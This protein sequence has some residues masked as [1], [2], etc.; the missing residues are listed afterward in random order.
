[1][2]P[3]QQVRVLVLSRSL[4]IWGARL[5]DCLLADFPPFFSLDSFWRAL[6]SVDDRIHFAPNLSKWLLWEEPFFGFVSPSVHASGLDLESH[7]SQ[8]STYLS[9][10]LSVLP[11]ADPSDASKPARSITDHPFNAR[12]RFPYLLAETLKLKAG[13]RLRLHN[14]YRQEDWKTLRELA[15]REPESRMS[16]LRMAL[17]KL[18]KYHRQLWMSMYKVSLAPP[19]PLSFSPFYS[20]LPFGMLNRCSAS[21]ARLTAIRL[22]N[23]RTALRRSPRAPRHDARPSNPVS[24][25]PLLRRDPRPT[26]RVLLLIQ[27]SLHSHSHSRSWSWRGRPPPPDGRG[28]LGIRRDRNVLAGVGRGIASGVWEC[29]TVVGLSSG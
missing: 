24:R 22:G 3:E 1:M 7:F 18:W 28:I 21:F 17:E 15:G 27:P 5:D 23:R 11:S 19:P 10:R 2:N 6:Q 20:P 8:L 12:L 26:S 9:S 25:P 29:G 4:A 14:A 16:R 13:L